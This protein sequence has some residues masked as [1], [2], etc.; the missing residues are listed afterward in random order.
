MYWAV[1]ICWVLSWER[2]GWRLGG[3]GQQGL[4]GSPRGLD[5]KDTSSS[6]SWGPR[7][8]LG[9]PGGQVAG[10]PCQWWLISLWRKRMSS[11]GWGGLGRRRLT[12]DFM[13][14]DN[15]NPET[16]GCGVQG[17]ARLH[18][19]GFMCVCLAVS[20]VNAFLSGRR[21]KAWCPRGA[22]SARSWVC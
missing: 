1:I 20:S 16:I 7:G 14:K 4:W 11:W 17:G 12:L 2:E 5:L 8:K 15:R 13:G 22:R 6:D 21:V 3:Q 18:F 19:L 10:G 9:A